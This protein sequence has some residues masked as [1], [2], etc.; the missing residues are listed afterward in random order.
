MSKEMAE[1]AK[2]LIKL[3]GLPCIVSPEEAEA[4]CAELAKSETIHATLSEDMDALTFGTPN[5]IRGLNSKKQ[6]VVEIC[7]E[8]VLSEMGLTMDE[9]IDLCIL[10]G[11]DYTRTLP[12]IGPVRGYN[13][14]K[15]HGSIEAIIDQLLTENKDSK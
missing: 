8:T 1:D 4:Q 7:L 15:K 13:Y 10:C 2:R 3:M 14:I 11:C 12:G 6:P 9:F 5:L